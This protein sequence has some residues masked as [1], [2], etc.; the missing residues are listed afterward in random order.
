MLLEPDEG[1]EKKEFG[2]LSEN[3]GSR[4]HHLR[5]AVCVCSWWERLGI[6]C[7]EDP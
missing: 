6:I 3:Y 1:G 5:T 7:N 2:G 4:N